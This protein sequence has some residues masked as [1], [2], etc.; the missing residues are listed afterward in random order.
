MLGADSGEFGHRRHVLAAASRSV[1][2]GARASGPATAHQQAVGAPHPGDHRPVA[3]ADHELHAHGDLTPDRLDH[4]DHL[5]VALADGHAVDHL[6]DAV[7]GLELASRAR[8]CRPG[9]A[10]VTW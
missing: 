3:E 9:S 2:T 6:G 8:G 5:R 1:S 10:G 7:G 4:P